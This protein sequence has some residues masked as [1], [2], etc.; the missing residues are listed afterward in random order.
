MIE[1]KKTRTQILLG[2]QARYQVQIIP[3]KK[4]ELEVT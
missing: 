4:E 1:L 2:H 3:V